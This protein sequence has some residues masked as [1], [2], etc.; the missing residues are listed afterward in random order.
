MVS[1]LVDVLP[2]MA[3]DG[4]EDGNLIYRKGIHLSKCEGGV[5]VEEKNQGMLERLKADYGWDTNL[6]VEL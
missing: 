5:F 3:D 6:E 1:G 4:M 2:F